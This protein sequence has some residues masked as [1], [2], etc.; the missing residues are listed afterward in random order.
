MSDK[1]NVVVFDLCHLSNTINVQNYQKN[2][3]YGSE[4]V[5]KCLP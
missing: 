2:T 5:F 1:L 3:D 4:V